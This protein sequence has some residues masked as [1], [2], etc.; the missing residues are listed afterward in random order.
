MEHASHPLH[1][2]PAHVEI[3]KVALDPVVVTLKRLQIGAV[4]R[5]EIVDHANLEPFSQQ[6]LDQMRTD[7]TCSSCDQNS[8]ER[9]H[10][11]LP[12]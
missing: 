9:V 3:R 10:G 8:F 1:R 2:P 6:C 12:C 7:E 4:S 11:D 5:G